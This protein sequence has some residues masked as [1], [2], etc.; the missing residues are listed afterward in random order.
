MKSCLQ[1]GAI[2]HPPPD[3]IEKYEIEATAVTKVAGNR[4][5]ATSRSGQELG[6][7]DVRQSHDLDGAEQQRALYRFKM[8]A[9]YVILMHTRLPC[10]KKHAHTNKL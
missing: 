3:A 10:P 9:Q 7:P 2:T 5:C 8:V 6:F 4:T 1:S